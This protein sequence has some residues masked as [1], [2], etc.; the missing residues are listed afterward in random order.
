M[1]PQYPY[2][3]GQSPLWWYLG[4]SSAPI[5][6]FYH[7]VKNTQ[8]NYITRSS[9]HSTVSV[10]CTAVL[11]SY[12]LEGYPSCFLVNWFWRFTYCFTAHMHEISKYFLST[13]NQE[14]CL[15]NSLGAL[16]HR[17]VAGRLSEKRGALI[18]RGPRASCM[19]AGSTRS[20]RQHAP[21]FIKS[22]AVRRRRSKKV[23]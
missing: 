6:V 23:H 19:A 11:G 10:Y 21:F 17:P 20:S 14:Q 15:H 18:S 12:T 22:N 8:T 3:T 4:H 2:G 5:I 9:I 13:E 7:I 1:L 16:T